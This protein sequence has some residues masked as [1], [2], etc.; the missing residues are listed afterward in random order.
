MNNIHDNDVNNKDEFN[1]LH[2][3]LNTFKRTKNTNYRYSPILNGC[4][5]TRRDRGK[6]KNL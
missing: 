1:L 6:Y 3:I 4:T 5:N 2:D